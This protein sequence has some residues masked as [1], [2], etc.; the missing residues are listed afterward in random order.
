MKVLEKNDREKIEQFEKEVSQ[1]IE[2]GIK[3]S[4]ENMQK[5]YNFAVSCYADLCKNPFK[6]F[7]DTDFDLLNEITIE[8]C[9][10]GLK[11]QETLDSGSYF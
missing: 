1:M 6:G 8:I 4:D 10:K 2:K 9:G 11:E 7:S 5:F 3:N